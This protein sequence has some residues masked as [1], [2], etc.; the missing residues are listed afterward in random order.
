MK[1]LGS[2][3]RA[4]ILIGVPLCALLLSFT[5]GLISRLFHSGSGASDEHVLKPGEL[6][7]GTLD[8]ASSHEVEYTLE[9]PESCVL[10]RVK[11]NCPQTELE[12]T[13][14]AS[15]TDD[16]QD[17]D[18]KVTTE[19]GTGTI[20]I[21]RFTEPAV[22][23][24]EY[25]FRIA[26]R[27]QSAPRSVDRK[28]ERIPYSIRPELFETRVDGTLSAGVM[29]EGSISPETGGFRTFRVDV[30]PGARALRFDIAE[31]QSDLDL[32]A[33]RGH[34]VR[35]LSDPL[36]FA[37]HNY[38]RETLVIDSASSPPLEPGTWYVDVIDVQDDERPTPFKLLVTFDPS[39]PAEL[40]AIPVLAPGSSSASE[41]ARLDTLGGVELAST[42]VLA[43]ALVGVVEISTDDG[44]GSGTLLTGDGW[45]LTNAHV[46]TG[47]GGEM[48]KEV[49]ISMPIDP[50][51]PSVE[52][53]RGRVDR[54][55]KQRDLALVQV[56][57]GFYGQPLPAGYVF[58]T[59]DMGNADAL[60]I[61]DPLW[62]VGYPST[63]GQGSR[64][65]ITATRGVISGFDTVAFGT[66]LKTDATITLGNSGGAALDGRGRIVGVPT[67]TIELGS[68]HIGYVHP[69]S[70]L[71][72]EWRATL[73][74]AASRTK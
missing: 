58:P 15:D 55:D 20:A 56:S 40:L 26:Y 35:S 14:R 31:A 2:F 67:S 62:L 19:S 73:A 72:D 12:L 54:F 36:N 52:M 43:R 69:L 18:F 51:R 13:A 22:A 34:P 42:S 3:T 33:Q 45:I 66:V 30:P 50:R 48:C 47:L 7:Q 71:P 38:G 4:P 39:P 1:L 11:L 10:L 21:S 8:L 28:I 27:S 32:F 25:R 46:V 61:G 63:G 16:D 60:A 74:S 68:G 44:A 5:Q 23:A 70:A 37:Q 17:P 9:V 65:T 64:V 6:S 29:Q 41:R 49:V 53:F 24:G 59:V 57:S